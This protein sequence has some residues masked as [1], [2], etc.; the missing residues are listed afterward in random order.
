[1][2]TRSNEAW[3]RNLRGTGKSREQALEALRDY[4]M[5][6]VLVYLGRH[7]SDLSDWTADDLRHFAEDMVQDAVLDIQDN[8]D[9]FRGDAKFTTWAYSFVINRAAGEL[10]RSHYR[11]YSYEDLQEDEA[12][13]FTTLQ[14]EIS[15]VTPEIRAEQEEMTTILLDIIRDELT[16]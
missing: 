1:M 13:F 6:A 11:D 9:T 2:N 8:L 5:R 10:R 15:G 16:S 14:A 12:A 4:L 7:R 3:L